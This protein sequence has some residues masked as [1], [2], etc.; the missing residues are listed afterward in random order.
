MNSHDDGNNSDPSP[1]NYSRNR[2]V[3]NKGMSGVKEQAV[4]QEIQKQHQGRGNSTMVN[5]A[6]TQTITVTNNFNF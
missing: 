5:V 3:R 1:G 6:D 2:G 4:G